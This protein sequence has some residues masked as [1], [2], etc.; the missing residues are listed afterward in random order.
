MVNINVRGKEEKI[1]DT[2]DIQSVKSTWQTCIQ[3]LRLVHKPLK[4]KNQ[5]RNCIFGAFTYFNYQLLRSVVG[6]RGEGEGGVHQNA[7]VCKRGCVIANV[8]IYFF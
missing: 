5:D 8:D 2:M 6:G 1:F 4:N 7:K 3:N